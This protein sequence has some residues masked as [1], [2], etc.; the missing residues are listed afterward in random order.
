[1]KLLTFLLTVHISL[2]TFAQSVG[3]N[4]TIPDGSAQLDIVSTSAGLLIPRMTAQ[5]RLAIVA[6]AK[7]LLVF[8]TDNS[9]GLYFNDGN[10]LVADWKQVGA[11][12]DA[13]N[14]AGNSLTATGLLGTLSNNHIDLISNNEVRGRLSNLGEFVI[15]ATNTVV[16]GDLFGVVS[17]ATFPFAVNG[18][19]AFNG[20]GV[21]GSILGGNT[22]FPGVQGEYQGS[23]GPNTSGVKGTNL[24]NVAGTGF[25]LQSTTGPRV[26]VIGNTTVT[27]GQFTFG[28]HGSM[29]STDVRCGALIGDDFGIALGA[30]AYYSANL[31]D[32][33]VYGFGRAFEVG[34]SSGK[35]TEVFAGQP[36]THIGLGIYGG[37]MGG[38]LRGLVYGT[39]VKGNRYS[40]YVDGKSYVNQPVT[41][42]VSNSDGTRTP[43]YPIS[44]L[45]PEVYASG[46]GVLQNGE[47][48]LTFS[49]TFLAMADFED[50]VVTV[51][52]LGESKG[53]FIASQSQ[54]GFTIKENSNGKSNVRFSW[55]AMAR[56]KDKA[57]TSHAPELLHAN[58]D[59]QMEKVMFN[60]NNTTDT[61]GSI[62]WDGNNVQFTRPP[63]KKPDVLYAPGA[64]NK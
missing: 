34:A 19:S 4:T 42:L 16:P 35:T 56:R 55:I 6:P 21:Y 47:I 50:I 62:W 44:S 18:Y 46:K 30:L 41:E 31:T 52:P 45:A 28:V 20:A 36:N 60:D 13:W 11:G 49:E 23:A 48:S 57:I 38:W 15:G 17:N 58:F 33:S 2:A 10:S 5:Q 37:V 43:V 25:R 32:Y 53:L 8:Q 63:Q 26:G 3:I 59:A 9:S 24:S 64:R 14:I 7:G 12:N 27:N 40:L 51:S 61:P 29:N 1:M 54:R 22:I 39:H